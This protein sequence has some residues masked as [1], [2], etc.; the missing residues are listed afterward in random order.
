[1]TVKIWGEKVYQQ[2]KPLK[3]IEHPITGQKLAVLSRTAA[4][5]NAR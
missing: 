4:D 1:M 5:G 2:L 3:E